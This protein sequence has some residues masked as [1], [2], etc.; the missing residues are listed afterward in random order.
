MSKKDMITTIKDNHEH[1]VAL[2]E[3]DLVVKEFYPGV[4]LIKK[5]RHGLDNE[6]MTNEKL[7]HKLNDNMKVYIENKD[8]PYGY[9]NFSIDRYKY[10]IDKE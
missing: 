6:F 7:V 1:Q 2:E 9:C 10:V 5:D 3:A 8:E 4:F